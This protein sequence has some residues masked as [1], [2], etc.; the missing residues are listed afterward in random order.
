MTLPSASPDALPEKCAGIRG[1]LFDKDGTLL[2]YAASWTPV[3]RRAASLAARGD[4]ALADRLLALAGVDPTSGRA[5]PDSVMSAGTTVDIAG[6]WVTGGATYEVENLAGALDDLF[7]AA[8]TDMVPVTDLSVLFGRFKSH[9][10]KLGIA[11]SDSEAAVWA[12]A[13]AFGIADRIDFVA[14]YDSGYGSKPDPAVLAAF[15][16]A[17]G[18]LP[19]EVAV[20][21]DNTHDVGMGRAG[22]AG[23]TIGVLTGT[24][25][26]DSLLPLSD[27]CLDSVCDI[28]ALLSPVRS[29]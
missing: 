20:I 25:T 23:L 18:L 28:E 9:G 14:G 6:V 24:G 13:A 19:R 1:L 2:D 21:G 15:C 5:S 8:V 10:F 17:T 11:S 29:I 3:N 7:C 16:R 4:P 26:R 27:I 12:T 22:G